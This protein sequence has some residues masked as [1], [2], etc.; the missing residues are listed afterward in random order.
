MEGCFE[1]RE[2][3]KGMGERSEER[4]KKGE[5][6]G[7]AEGVKGI[8]KEGEKGGR[9]DFAWMVLALKGGSIAKERGKLL[10]T[11]EG[12]KDTLYQRGQAKTLHQASRS[13]RALLTPSC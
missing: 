10:G 13:S 9:K 2:K 3:E 8:E 11:E 12:G 7:G 1:S 5:E 6:R 4:E